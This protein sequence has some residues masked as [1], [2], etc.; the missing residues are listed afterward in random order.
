[1]LVATMGGH[2]QGMSLLVV[3]QQERS[4]AQNH[5]ETSDQSSWEQHIAVDRLPVAIH[6]AGQR[7]G[8][9]G[10]STGLCPF[11]GEMPEIG[12]PGGQGIRERSTPSA[13]ASCDKN[14]S[15]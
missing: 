11:C 9:F 2:E 14:R 5:T 10:I 4:A 6:I 7:R 3:Q 13:R 1:M 8:M 15:V 12:G